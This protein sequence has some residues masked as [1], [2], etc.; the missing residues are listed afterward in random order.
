MCYK[1]GHL[2]FCNYLPYF[3]NKNLKG[4]NGQVFFFKWGD[5]ICPNSTIVTSTNNAKNYFDPFSLMRSKQHVVLVFCFI[6]STHVFL[7]K[8]IKK[9]ATFAPFPRCL[10]ITE[11]VSFNI[12]SEA[13]YVYILSRQKLINNA[14][15]GPFW[16]VFENLKAWSLRSNSVTR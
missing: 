11:K 5:I 12:A 3:F 9:Q 14:K 1:E 6:W 10:K 4:S 16:R 13:N 2:N 7:T 8:H 15:N